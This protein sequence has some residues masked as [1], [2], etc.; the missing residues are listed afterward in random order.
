MRKIKFRL[1]KNNEVVG[2]EEHRLVGDGIHPKQIF[3]Y[4]SRTGHPMSWKELTLCPGE[5][6][7][8]DTKDQFTGLH[9]KNGKEIYEGDILESYCS[10][11]S[12]GRQDVVRFVSNGFWCGTDDDLWMPNSEYCEIIGNIHENPELLEDSCG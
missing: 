8:H 11:C 6:L 9:D 3:I 2:Y 7:K 10:E 1:I 5:Y 4:H 12:K